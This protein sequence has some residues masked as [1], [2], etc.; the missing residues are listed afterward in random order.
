MI[1]HV[2]LFRLREPLSKE[3]C[4]RLVQT[5]SR[6]RG[7]IDGVLS[8]RAGADLGCNS[9]NWDFAVVVD[10]PDRAS[11][12]YYQ[13]HPAHVAFV[14]DELMPLLTERAAVQFDVNDP[15]RS[16]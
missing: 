7:Q 4:R 10:L 14:W 8:A 12:E 2:A 6:F 9:E 16:G 11:L 15:E 13:R 5:V 3:A 1:Q